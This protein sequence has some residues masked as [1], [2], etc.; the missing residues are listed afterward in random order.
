MIDEIE[1][2]S[3]VFLSCILAGAMFGLIFDFFRIV[4]RSVSRRELVTNICDALFWI[5]ATLFFTGWIF[6]VNDGALRWYVFA[7][8]LIGAMLYFMLISRFFVGAGVFI[9]SVLKKIFIFILKIILM[10][11]SFIVRKSRKAVFF[12]IAPLKKTG[13]ASK[14]A[15]RRIGNYFKLVKMKIKKV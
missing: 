5:F 7:S 15:K 2:Q 12:V 8:T 6:S 9:V 3:P 14:R 4:R 1:V 10:P 11:V 13:K